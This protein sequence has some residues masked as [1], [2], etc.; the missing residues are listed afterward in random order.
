M[1]VPCLLRAS[2]LRSADAADFDHDGVRLNKG[3][4]GRFL[5]KASINRWYAMDRNAKWCRFKPDF[6]RH[7]PRSTSAARSAT[8]QSAANLRCVSCWFESCCA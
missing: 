7:N 4:A 8:A 5:R 3:D 1:A 6:S 2:L